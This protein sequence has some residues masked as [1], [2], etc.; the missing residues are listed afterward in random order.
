MSL[1][2]DRGALSSALVVTYAGERRDVTDLYPFGFVSNGAYTTADIVVK[3]Q[4]ASVAPFVKLEN[5]TD[6]RYEEVF[7]YP[8]PRRRF[9]AGIRYTV[10]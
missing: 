3:Y 2:Y 7:G 6:E 1:A 10:R 5:A 8:S 9:I 4:I